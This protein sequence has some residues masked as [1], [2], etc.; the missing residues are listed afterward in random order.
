MTLMLDPGTHVMKP[1]GSCG[2]KAAQCLRPSCKQRTQQPLLPPCAKSGT[3]MQAT[4][5]VAFARGTLAAAQSGPPTACPADA[6]Q[7][8]FPSWSPGEQA[9]WPRTCGALARHRVNDIPLPH[10]EVCIQAAG[11]VCLAAAAAGQPELAELEILEVHPWPGDRYAAQ[12]FLTAR[13]NSALCPATG[14]RSTVS[15]HHACW[16]ALGGLHCAPIVQTKCFHVSA[17]RKPAKNASA[18]VMCGHHTL[19][20]RGSA[21]TA[22]CHPRS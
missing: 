1:C 9:R 7:S 15:R 6:A 10:S 4:I 14:Q 17:I 12:G 5:P 16:T 13:F 18:S 19:P 3:S 8:S 2:I 21:G 20:F 22:C 11:R